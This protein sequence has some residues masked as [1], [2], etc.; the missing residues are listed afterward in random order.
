MEMPLSEPISEE[1]VRDW[2]NADEQQEIIDEIIVN[3]VNK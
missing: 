2:V 1:D 3:I